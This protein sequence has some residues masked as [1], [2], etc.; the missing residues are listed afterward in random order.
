M[1]YPQGHSLRMILSSCC[2]LALLVSVP[3]GQSQQNKDDQI[4]VCPVFLS[5][6]T[7]TVTDK[8]DRPVTTLTHD[9]FTVYEDNVPRAVDFW[10]NCSKADC[11]MSLAIL[12]DLSGSQKTSPLANEVRTGLARFM[13]EIGAN[14]YT[15]L[16][17]NHTVQLLTDWTHEPGAIVDGLNRATQ[18]KST[19]AFYDALYTSI[20]SIKQR[21]NLRRVLLLITDGE[22]T[23]SQHSEQQVERLLKETGVMVYGIHI[24]TY[25]ES[26]PI[27]YGLHTLR[28]F[29]SLTGGAAFFPRS[30]KNLREAFDRITDELHHQYVVGY[31]PIN[32]K[33]DGKWR[34]VKLSV[35]P[36]AMKDP[37]A[38]DK[39]AKSVEM[40][41]RTREGYYA[42]NDTSPNPPR[43]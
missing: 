21:E 28:H 26:P 35:Q 10:K 36:V 7:A 42:P 15:L 19:T 25:L 9:A 37:S 27:S 39:P 41:V 43:R 17:F 6:L 13:K 20:E 3:R 31:Y 40:K 8:S 16:G 1:K 18:M 14:E 34:R 38:A 2:V 12:Y 29:S 23:N 24:D 4:I 33:H 22:D 32:T 5:V 11:P 30:A